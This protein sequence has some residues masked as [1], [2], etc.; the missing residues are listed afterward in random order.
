MG[1]PFEYQISSR[2]INLILEVILAENQIAMDI[3]QAYFR[4]THFPIPWDSTTLEDF[5]PDITD[6]IGYDV[7]LSARFKNVGAPRFIFNREQ[8]Q[9]N[10]NMEVELWDEDYQDYFLTIKYHDVH[11]DF[12]MWLEGMNLTTE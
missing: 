6:F 10:L 2:V 1:E 3:P 8:M 5:I 12:D 7:P 9:V 4:K 11:I